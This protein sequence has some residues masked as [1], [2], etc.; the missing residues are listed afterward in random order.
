MKKTTAI[1]LAG[2]ILLSACAAPKKTE[3]LSMANA[4]K[5]WSAIWQQRSAEYRALCF[6]A[7][8]L[9][10]LRLDESLK[11]QGT[12]PY[13]VVTDLDE[14]LLDNSPEN[15]ATA[16]TNQEFDPKPWGTWTQKGVADTVPGAPSFF[17]Y[18]ASKGVA[19]FYITNRSEE[20]K[21]ATIKNLQLYGLP[22]ADDAHFLA[23]S[24]TSSKESRRQSLLSTYN[25]VLLCGDNLGDFDALYDN[26]PTEE[27]RLATTNRLR[28]AFGSRYIV[29]PNL[30]YGDWEN[31]LFNN[32]SK[33]TAPQKDSILRAKLKVSRTE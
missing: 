14:T 22:D 30:S 29:I 3:R 11:T 23:R 1:L 4:G 8:N 21:A 5:V 16:M 31:A 10:K 13:A 18:A 6:Q 27:S 15:G 2:I 9:A 26:K 12:K 33:L 20:E 28:A 24:T 32:R 17:K 25:I 7:Y 19:V